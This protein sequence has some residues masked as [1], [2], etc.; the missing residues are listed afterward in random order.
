MK[1]IIKIINEINKIIGKNSTIMALPQVDEIISSQETETAKK[2]NFQENELVSFITDGFLNTNSETSEEK[3]KHN[4][5]VLINRAKTNGKIEKFM[6][7]REDDFL[8]QNWQWDVLSDTTN[9]ES[10]CTPLSYQLRKAYA[11]REAHL[12]ENT[13]ISGVRVPLA[14]NKQ[15]NEAMKMVDKTLGNF[16]L[17]SRFRSTKHFTINTP[18]EVTGN[19]NA[20]KTDRD[21]III[22][23]IDEFI[24]SN[25]GYSL[26][27]HDAYLDITHEGLPISIDAVVLIKEENYN[28]IMSN[29]KTATALSQRRVIKYT[30]DTYLAI[31]MMLTEMGVLPS[32]INTK[33]ASYDTI[34]SNIISY[35][36]RNLA[37]KNGLLF[38]RSHGGN[39]TNGHFSNYYD[40]KNQDYRKAEEESVNF[41]IKKFP[42]NEQILRRYLNEN[43]AEEVVEQIGIDNLLSAINEYNHMTTVR[44][45]QLLQAHNYDRGTITS[46]MHKQFTKMV[47]LINFFYT[48][49][50]FDSDFEGKE[51]IE[52]YIQQFF[53]GRTCKEQLEALKEVWKNLRPL[54]YPMLSQSNES[55]DYSMIDKQIIIA[56]KGQIHK[57][58]EEIKNLNQ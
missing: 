38:D 36:I 17:P 27:Y 3:L 51:K 49:V 19:Y 18:L 57:E 8:P 30:G 52:F 14:T 40:E 35:S 33:Y 15:V 9:W 11:L 24:K 54:I 48:Q 13:I 56:A 26:S 6:I 23:S 2:I 50:P 42:K 55:L 29:P 37:S 21:F 46:T 10:V 5:K 22:D 25:Y 43:N 47:S 58:F 28:R 12:T 53:Q 45:E 1:F 16:L 32:Q 44:A 31:N 4:L 39:G 34:T 7:I 41:L 20:V